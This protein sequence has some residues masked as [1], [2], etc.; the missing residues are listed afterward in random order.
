M[1]VYG[2]DFLAK[3]FY[4]G[5]YTF[6]LGVT[7]ALAVEGFSKYPELFDLYQSNLAKEIKEN[8]DINYALKHPD[9]IDEILALGDKSKLLTSQI[10]EY[11]LP[12]LLEKG[13][14]DIG[15]EKDYNTYANSLI[16][17]CKENCVLDDYVDE[18][19]EVQHGF[20][21]IAMEFILLGFTNG[22]S[23]SKPKIKITTI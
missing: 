10:V 14:T 12:K 20:Y 19:N 23:S 8:L 21:S 2:K 1:A 9:K 11:L 4:I 16:E 15:E 3:T 22:K 5:D 17:Y 18:D 6:T 7:R 13:N